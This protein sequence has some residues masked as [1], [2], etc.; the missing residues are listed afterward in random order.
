MKSTQTVGLFESQ[1]PQLQ[2]YNVET[3]IEFVYH[4]MQTNKD[5]RLSVVSLFLLNQI[6]F[7]QMHR[8]TMPESQ[9]CT[10]GTDY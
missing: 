10:T 1:F 4:K 6:I 2:R 7:T 5:I 3:L 9:S 8:I